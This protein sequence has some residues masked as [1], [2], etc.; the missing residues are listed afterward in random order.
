MTRV[1][2]QGQM[3]VPGKRTGANRREEGVDRGARG[4]KCN[5]TITPEM[6]G[7]VLGP[8]RN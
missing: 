5:T 2:W 4:R 8:M 1:E 3:D 6:V 7:L